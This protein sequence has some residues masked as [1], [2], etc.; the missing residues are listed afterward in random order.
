MTKLDIDDFGL[1]HGGPTSGKSTLLANYLQA[2]GLA[3][4]PDQLIFGYFMSDDDKKLVEETQGKVWYESGPKRTLWNCLCRAGL[5]YA[6]I[7][8]EEH[9]YTIITNLGADSLKQVDSVTFFRQPEELAN[10]LASRQKERGSTESK[11]DHFQ[12]AKGWYDSW[13]KW[14]SKYSE[15]IELKEGEYMSDYFNVKITETSVSSVDKIVYERTYDALRALG[16]FDLVLPKPKK[17]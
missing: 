10:I 4:D 16:Y 7:L 1:I 12:V 8:L 2:G 14:N 11:I 15:V 3:I 9:N 13:L 17:S 5:A 6:S